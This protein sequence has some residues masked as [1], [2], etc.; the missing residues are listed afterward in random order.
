MSTIE[1]IHELRKKVQEPVRKY[2]DIA[3]HLI[4]D[5][6]SI[7]VTRAFLRAG[8]SPTVAT[9][10]FLVC[11]LVGSSLVALGGHWAVA[12]FGVVFL[13]YVFDCVDGEVARYHSREEL[14]WGFHDFMFHLYVKSAFFVALGIYAVGVTG[15]SWVFLLALSALL[16]TLFLKFLHDAAIILNV[17]YVLLRDPKERARFVEQLTAAASD[18]E[19]STAGDLPGEHTPFHFGSPLSVVRSAITNFDL[20]VLYF[21][22]AAVVDV[23]LQPFTVAGIPC[24]VK[25]ALLAF[26]ALI[27]PLDFFD[28][29]QSYIR[30]NKFQVESRRL[31]RRAHHFRIP[32]ASE[33][34]VERTAGQTAGPT[35]EHTAGHTAEH[36]AEHSAKRH[37]GRGDRA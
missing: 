7:H 26:Y 28:H 11:G 30:A 15:R 14:V 33:S 5:R 6:V 2:N 8:W 13:Y 34:A 22:V 27:L 17:R 24:D 16:A 35:A 25:T 20:S 37:G 4:G 29:V 12:G 31:L 1:P 32:R 23:W 18:Q 3:G 9:I 19:L 10:A 21:L 36:A